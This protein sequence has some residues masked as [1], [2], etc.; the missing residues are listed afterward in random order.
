MI[1][2]VRRPRLWKSWP[3]ATNLGSDQPTPTPSL[4]ATAAQRVEAGQ[5]VRQLDG[6]VVGGDEHARTK[7]H[8]RGGRGRP[9]QRHQRVVEKGRWIVLLCR[10][11]NVVAYPDVAEPE[12]LCV[13]R[14]F[15]NGVGSSGASVLREMATNLHH[16]IVDA[17]QRWDGR[18]RRRDIVSSPQ[19]FDDLIDHVKCGAG[20][21]Q[22]ADAVSFEPF[23][24][25]IDDSV[26]SPTSTC[27]E[28]RRA[29]GS[30]PNSRRGAAKSDQSAPTY[31]S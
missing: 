28:S 16:P 18:L 20:H 26:T 8:V 14:R 19:A 4:Q 27:G 30:M 5:C 23:V 17:T 22:I 31:T 15:S 10:V 24:Q 9:A 21:C 11:H 7:A 6:V 12:L 25:H 13:A 3:S 29:A 1:S 2:S